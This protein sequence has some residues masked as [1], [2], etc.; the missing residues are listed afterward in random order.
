M[1][2]LF[3]I[4]VLC[5]YAIP[6][7][8]K[9]P[10]VIP[11]MGLTALLLSSIL[12]INTLYFNSLGSGITVLSGSFNV[13]AINLFLGAFMFI[14]V[15]LIY[16]SFPKYNLTNI[17]TYNYVGLDKVTTK[18]NDYMILSLLSTTGSFLLISANSLII[19][20][21]AIELQSF[22]VYILA[23]MSKESES[24]T[25]AG[26]KYFLLGSLASCVILLGLAIIYYSTG[27]INLDD[28]Y[29][30]YNVS[31]GNNLLYIN[32]GISLIVTGMLFKV[33]AVPLHFWSID[34]YQDT[35][36]IITTWLTIMPKIGILL[37]LLDLQSGFGLL[38]LGY[39]L[40]LENLLLITSGLS[41]IV[42]SIMGLSQT[43]IKRLLAYSTISHVGFMLLILAVNSEESTSSLLFYIIQYSF[44]NL[45]LFLGLL[46]LGYNNVNNI[47]INYNLTSGN[48]LIYISE[49]RSIVKNNFWLAFTL[50]VAI[51]SMAGI[52]PL[53]GFF[54]KQAVLFSAA[55]R[56]YYF[57]TLLCVIVSVIS[58]TYYL[59]LIVT[60]YSDSNSHNNSLT[61]YNNINTGNI[62]INT[63][64]HSYILATFTILSLFFIFNSSLLLNAT[65][66]VSL[67]IF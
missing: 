62:Y 5:F 56:N 2:I 63:S 46:Y 21:L 40:S 37:F 16:L 31:S 34:V 24:S 50:I 67:S 53:P 6:S 64:L 61:F 52:P 1:L 14:L 32:I 11:G 17:E 8:A 9:L 35:P 48:D 4:I 3:I 60:F 19:I 33:A 26:L 51:F 58:A 7:L 30:L 65:Q 15:G 38:N 13:T 10:L 18:F 20:Y 43:K 12:A 55:Q 39:N 22:G 49:L 54:A 28:I 57:M 66:L 25:S 42:G 23:A 41:L 36:T 27:L 47:R 59:K 45:V 44:T 29:S